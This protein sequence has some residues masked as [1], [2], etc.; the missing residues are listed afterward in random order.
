VRVGKLNP[1]KKK[2]PGQGHQKERSTEDINMPFYLKPKAR[3][4]GVPVNRR[5]GCRKK[6]G[7]KGKRGN[8]KTAV[9]C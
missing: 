3:E 5:W 4:R 2:K 9:D 7:Q 6:G 1:Q 8:G